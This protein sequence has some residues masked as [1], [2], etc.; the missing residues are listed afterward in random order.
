[1]KKSF[2]I[3]LSLPFLVGCGVSYSFKKYPIQDREFVKN[4]TESK[5]LSEDV[6]EA[7]LH[8]KIFAG[9]KRKLIYD[10]FG[11]PES[12]FISETGLMEIWFYKDFYVGFDKEGKLV[13]YGEY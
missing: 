9:M 4:Y 11:K 6:K 10:L 7:I 2:F 5:N 1:M 13:K 12:K 8:G 3:I